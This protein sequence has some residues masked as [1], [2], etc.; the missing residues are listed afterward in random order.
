M[1]SV[2]DNKLDSAIGRVLDGR[3]ELTDF[4]A[5]GGMG[6]VYKATQR[7][8]DRVVAIKLLDT[9][10]GSKEEFRKR[11]FLEASLCA[12]LSHPN[13][14]RIIDFGCDQDETYYIAMEFLD[15]STVKEQI[16]QNGSMEP[17]RA[18]HILIQVCSALIEAHEQGLVHRDLKSSNL[19][20]SSHAMNEDFVKL[21]DFGIVKEIASEREITV[22]GAMLG[23]PT[24]MSPEQ[25]N[26]TEIDG[27]SDIYSL[28]VVF[29]H[30]LTGTLPFEDC[31]IVRVLLGH[32][33]QTPPSLEEAN[34]G[35]GFPESLETIVQTCL[36]KSRAD[37]YPSVLHLGKIRIAHID[38]VGRQFCFLQE[39]FENLRTPD[40]QTLPPKCTV[41]HG[42]K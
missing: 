25:I 13:I 12:R 35:V 10:V 42:S 39:I 7:P 32:L 24:F 38:Q 11:F 28:G 29:F 30:M 27:R 6:K 2:G 16:R 34:P 37:R 5:E 15:G 41:K 18:I 1:N 26:N 33:E 19:I 3:F 40:I 31:S 23:S 21:V 36:Q 4:I 9:K 17:I 8:L 14:V 20:L 22:T